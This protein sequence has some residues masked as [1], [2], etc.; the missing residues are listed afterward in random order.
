[1]ATS[2]QRRAEA[3]HIQVGGDGTFFIFGTG[4]NT[5]LN[6]RAL[7]VHVDA[8][9]TALEDT[10]GVDIKAA[11][12]ITNN[13]IKAFTIISAEGAN[14]GRVQLSTGSVIGIK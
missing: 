5:G 10:N 3:V 13:T 8:V 14:I 1:M 4:D 2:Q 7:Q 9:F 11:L 12:G 6:Y